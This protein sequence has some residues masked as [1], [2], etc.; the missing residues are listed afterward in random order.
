MGPRC[1]ERCA[2]A[3]HALLQVQ[4]A[5]RRNGADA[6]LGRAAHTLRAVRADG[7]LDSKSQCLTGL[8]ANRPKGDGSRSEAQQREDRNIAATLA[9][10]VERRSAFLR[11]IETQKV[12]MTKLLFSSVVV[13]AL[14]QAAP[15][16]L[17]EGKVDGQKIEEVKKN[18]P[19]PPA[20]GKNLPEQAGAQEPSSKVQG[21]AKNDDIFVNGVLT[22][23]GAPKDTETT[24]AKHS[25]RVAAEDKLPIAAF[26]LRRLTDDQRREIA[27]QLA[28]PRRITPAGDGAVGEHQAIVGA[29]VPSTALDALIPV[30]EA[31]AAQ[32]PELR[33]AGSMRAGGKLLLVDLDNML[34]IGVLEPARPSIPGEK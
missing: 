25:E 31:V 26:R 4:P 13:L 8:E 12:S 30:P 33:G 34:V 32:F 23:P 7:R 22:V 19:V 28:S 21:T 15:V 3:A 16:A 6:E 17:A 29:L 2:A 27:Q 18:D 11:L 1:F 20:T 5:W 9:F 14:L 10:P 24:P